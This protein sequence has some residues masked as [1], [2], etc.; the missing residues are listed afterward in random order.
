[1][2]I[3]VMITR[4]FDQKHVRGRQARTMSLERY[5]PLESLK[6]IINV[7][8]TF[9]KLTRGKKLGYRSVERA[10]HNLVVFHQFFLYIVTV[11]I[12]SFGAT[13][14]VVAKA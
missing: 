10:G 9:V 12:R 13:C 4:L 8:K 3:F 11:G 14:I 5:L 7:Q 2:L 1:M 6:Q